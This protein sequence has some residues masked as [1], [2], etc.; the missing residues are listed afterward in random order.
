[1]AD[2]DW[3]ERERLA[4]ENMRADMAKQREQ[5][6]HERDCQAY[7]SFAKG[8]AGAL[9]KRGNRGDEQAALAWAA[10]AADIQNG[11]WLVNS[12][13]ASDPEVTRFQSLRTK[14][15]YEGKTSRLATR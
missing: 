14:L 5:E 9:F 7:A 13:I 1:M 3:N 8:K 11:N 10:A 12:A 6:Q 2:G 4:V 15:L